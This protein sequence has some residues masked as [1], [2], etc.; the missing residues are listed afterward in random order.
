MQIELGH[1]DLFSLEPVDQDRRKM[2]EKKIQF[3]EFIDL[4][5]QKIEEEGIA[6]DIEEDIDEKSEDPEQFKARK[7]ILLH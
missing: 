3:K 4:C 5:N 7:L 2:S 6:V 1:S